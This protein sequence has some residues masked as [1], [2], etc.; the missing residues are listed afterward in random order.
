MRVFCDG[1]MFDHVQATMTSVSSQRVAPQ[2]SMQASVLSTSITR[3]GTTF[4]LQRSL[5][6]QLGAE[7]KAIV[8]SAWY[9]LLLMALILPV[10]KW[11]V[12]SYTMTL[13]AL[14]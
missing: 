6:T 5:G 3:A 8:T 4:T 7:E 14:T 2:E 1:F 12:C 10:L 13:L 9:Q 11:L